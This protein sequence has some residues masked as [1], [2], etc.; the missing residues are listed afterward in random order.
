MKIYLD[1][2][3]LV[4]ACLNAIVLL[5]EC[6]FRRRNVHLGRIVL[7]S[8]AGAALAVGFLVCG[9][10]TYK[11]LFILLYPMGVFLMVFITFGKTTFRYFLGNTAAFYGMSALLAALLMQ[12]QGVA[13][14]G[15]RISLL[16]LGSAVFLGVLYRFIPFFYREKRAAGN[17]CLVRLLYGG[18]EVSGTG[19]WDTGNSLTEP[20]SRKPVAIG[21]QAFLRPLFAGGEEPLFR[22]IPFRSVG[23]GGGMLAA[24]RLDEMIIEEPDRE[25]RRLRKPWMA[26]SGESV[27]ADR[28]YQVILHPEMMREA[29]DVAGKEREK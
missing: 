7:A 14:I 19:L 11:I 22:Y 27:S 20:F 17:Y 1:V 10:H 28:A 26:V 12:L 13:G 23:N 16:L 5:A 2:F 24:F 29:E 15:G 3:F 4:N 21:E 6:M 9:L 18:R 8:T 25:S